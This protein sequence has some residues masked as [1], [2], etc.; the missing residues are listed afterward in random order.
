MHPGADPPGAWR[1][2]LSGLPPADTRRALLAGVRRI[3]G[4]MLLR[5]EDEPIGPDESFVELGFDSL[6][7]VDFK[8][9]LER[10]LAAKLDST[11]V[12]DC[13]TP[14]ALADHLAE[15]LGIGEVHHTPGSSARPAQSGATASDE[16]QGLD[17]DELRE[18]VRRHRAELSAIE[19]RRTAP[20]AV[21]GQACRF[22]GAN[23]PETFWRNQVAGRD[24]ITEVPP[25]RWDIDAFYDPDRSAP[26]KMYT[27]CGGFVE[28]IDRFDARLF[29]IS[30]REAVQMDPQHR[31]LLEVTW[32]ALEDAGFA[33]RALRGS[34]TAVYIGTKSPEYY[35]GNTLWQP[36]DAETF[37]GTGNS[38]STLA[39]RLSYFFGWNG[40]CYAIDTACSSSLVAVH[41]GVVGLRS[42]ESDLVF[43]GG[44]NAL[45]DP[46]SSLATCRASMLS[47]DGRC[48]T[49]DARADGYVRA[50]GCGVVVL[51]RLDDALRD[52]DR[53]LAVIRGTAINQDGASAGLT[54]PSRP[55]QEDVLR[56]A[57]A[58]A[59]LEPDDIDYLE[60]HGTGTSLGDPIEVSALDGVF[61]P[62]ERRGRPLLVS[63]VK[64]HVGHAET[65]AGVAG[66]IKLVQALRHDALPPHLHLET[67]NPH[68]DWEHT[69]VEVPKE[70][71]PWPR[72][73]RPRRGGVNSFGFSG[74]NAHVVVEE[75]PV[76]PARVGAPLPAPY[77]LPFSAQS[78]EAV[79][80]LAARHA[81]ALERSDVDP[82]D[83]CYTASVGREAFACR[84]TAFGADREALVADLRAIAEDDA[85]TRIARAP[86]DPP[87]IAF[88]FTGQGSQ[89][90]GMG[91][92]LYE[93]HPV[94]RAALDRAAAALAPHLPHP[95]ISVLW[96]EHSELL[97]R[98]DFTQPAL[99]AFEV[100][101]CELWSSLGLRPDAVLGH[102]VG[103]YAA[104]VVAGVL[105]LDDAARLIAGRGRLMVERC[106]P[107]AM[108][109]VFAEPEDV[110]EHMERHAKELS[111]AVHN[112]PGRFVASGAFDAIAE[113]ERALADV[114]VRTRRLE[115]SH[116]F[117][118][119]LMAPML[120]P[121]GELVRA[122]RLSP[123][124]CTF[125]SAKTARAETDL[126]T[127]PAYW[128]DHVREPVRFAAAGRALADAA[129]SESGAWLWLEV[130]PSPTLLSLVSSACEG[131]P[132]TGLPTAREGRPGVGTF[133][134][135][136]AG[137]W[138]AG[139]PVDWESAYRPFAVRKRAIP[140]YPFQRERYWLPPKGERAGGSGPHPFPGSRH[141][142]AD[143]GP[144]HV[145]YEV[146]LSPARQ[147]FLAEHRVYGAAVLPATAYLDWA[148]AAGLSE[149]GPEAAL[150]DVAIESALTVDEAGALAQL[151]LEPDDDG[152]LRFT[153]HSRAKENG[154]R[155]TRHATGR[156]AVSSE[157][158]GAALDTSEAACDA[159][160]TDELY[161]TLARFGLDYGPRF[162]LLREAHVAGERCVGV[163]ALDPAHAGE[164]Q[165]HALHPALLDAC[166]HA[167]APISRA[168][169]FDELYLPV[170]VASVERFAE[171][172][173]EARVRTTLLDA[174]RPGAAQLRFDVELFA[175]DGAP[176]IALRGLELRR[177]KRAS[178][179]RGRDPLEG[180]GHEVRWVRSDAH[181]GPAESQPTWTIAGDGDG[182]A[183]ELARA[184]EARGVRTARVPSASHASLDAPL[185]DLGFL[186]A[187]DGGDL[188]P[189]VLGALRV[190]REA[191]DD[192][193]RTLWI[194]RGAVSVRDGDPLSSP[195]LAAA[196]GLVRVAA[197]ERRELRVACVDL[198]PSHTLAEQAAALV[199]ECL[200]ADDE[201]QV[202][203]RT[204]VGESV[205]YVARLQPARGISLATVAPPERGTWRLRAA[206][207]G[208]F[209]G[210]RALPFACPNP[211]PG[212]VQL[213]LRAAGLNFKDP[214]YV[215]GRLQEDG[216]A[217]EQPLGFEA[218]GTVLA[219]G[220]GVTRCAPGD[221]VLAQ[222][223][224]LL[225]NRATVP[226]Q[227]VVRVPPGLDDV[228][229][230]VLPT[231]YTTALFGLERCARLA[232]GE[233]VLVHA[234]AGGLGQAALHVAERAG[235]RVVATASRSKWPRLLA[236][237]VETIF[238]SRTHDY[239]EAIRAAT[240][241]RGVD[242]VF[243]GLAGEHVAPSLACLREGGR[244]V[245][246]ARLGAWTPEQVRAQRPDVDYVAY[247]FSAVA[248]RDPE[249]LAALLD[250]LA[251]GVASGSLAPLPTRAFPVA[252]APEAV[253][254]LAAGRQ[255]GKI[256]LR[257]PP[258]DADATDLLVRPDASYAITGG[259]GALGLL[260][261]EA[262]VERGARHLVLVGRRTPGDAVQG[263]LAQ[264]AGRGC[265]V[266]TE[267]L[268]V[269]DSQAVR[270]MVLGIDPP[271]AGVVHAA[272]VLT[273]GLLAN[274]TWESF[275]RAFAPKIA[276]GWNLHLATR[277]LSLDFF[278]MF[279]SMAG[280]VGSAGQGPYA[281]AN[282]FL[283][284]L[285]EHRRG[286]GLPAVALAY[287]PWAD[288]G[289]AAR[290]DAAGR[291]RLER[292][293]LSWIEPET[294]IAA[295]FASLATQ[296]RRATVGLLPVDWPRY[297][298]SLGKGPPPF[299]AELAGGGAAHTGTSSA[300]WRAELDG[301]DAERRPAVLVE[302]LRVELASVLGFADAAQVDPRDRLVDLG[303]DSL[304]AVDL[305]TRLEARLAVSL[306]AGIVLEQPDLEHL[307]AVLL[308]HLEASPN[309]VREGG[310]EHGVD[311]E[312]LAEIESMSDEEAERLMGSSG[313]DA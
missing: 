308:A 288:V 173:A 133:V 245:E 189:G 237:G 285:A 17:A 283:D 91:R 34:R 8:T 275:A 21:V 79:R 46:M 16:L 175:P 36:E 130:G 205:R 93:A 292:T 1:A 202:A 310:A 129:T 209:E 149:L 244:Y 103:E 165:R 83:T 265:T 2:E 281:A 157:Q 167:T 65:A 113:L 183:C 185:V 171:P 48:K 182:L 84:A 217:A 117:H 268:D 313:V 114:D 120:A 248:A 51:K 190:A 145:L 27:R 298:A 206:G 210:L 3:A 73:D 280:M 7:A 293:G 295:L 74:T 243:D 277:D 67:P 240:G 197:L 226:E 247:D 304:L 261:A 276:G 11:L 10:R 15:V 49:F 131:K 18:L 144:G 232:P 250:E 262:L 238:D 266:R 299:F 176:C 4:A 282:A 77:T 95:L 54:V 57:L 143:R 90:V 22:A 123:P 305:R 208:T 14:R 236:Q 89:W 80:E 105:P 100:A 25:T 142:L 71:A 256:A 267:A 239:A 300:G 38:Q 88:L 273:D 124:E 186:E 69:V 158:A 287:G 177:A 297:L 203:L 64:T 222:Y 94:F 263:R 47:E 303:V 43:A 264:L 233:T 188:I 230:A 19:A 279:S 258:G 45:L 195:H 107:G 97:A 214:L 219:V 213:E 187:E 136:A 37:F 199:D 126:I 26:G 116:A 135:A 302:Q 70:G 307:A 118:S 220:E 24:G 151:A 53:V 9:D 39:G 127:D 253:R 246:L 50:E 138:C 128:I 87:R 309:G 201:N 12:F 192:G 184:M 290:V 229:A 85:Q 296:H 154:G 289:M 134:E 78:A 98:T 102:S 29:G 132:I 40:P 179:M 108:L 172:P 31:I 55:A 111:V 99:F 101:A 257:I 122:A 137:A 278:C 164:V 104:A 52:G 59:G 92:E 212:E 204:E 218:A 156:I 119:P 254:A 163:V 20:I 72:G 147:P 191:P 61:G 252:H 33:P 82:G 168:H 234:A 223:V 160:D 109:A 32:E 121:F 251:E 6:M 75:A 166:F 242:V 170:R 241:G 231:V 225:A 249:L 141:E 106:E 198:A 284:A 148:L 81:E 56:T 58:S 294:G 255:V 28:P 216:D 274:Q 146:E 41:C 150:A 174:P 207:E 271:L 125:V 42:G 272:G 181:E 60:A 200:R 110:S 30:P 13:T 194:T 235:A 139:A 63:S 86:A 5:T 35:Q 153:L 228:H 215:L 227:A 66:L 155:W 311:E 301:A 180:L 96:G 159:V 193:H 306:P 260:V 286:Q 196:L 224:D 269:A 178:L 161:A 312:L 23:D 115:V 162:R 112:A 221:R 270:R 44:V 140:T 259:L 291:A 62:R 68:I 76:E 211:G 152:A 169:G